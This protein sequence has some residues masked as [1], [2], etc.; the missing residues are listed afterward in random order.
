MVA[1]DEPKFIS[2]PLRF[3]PPPLPPE[4]LLPEVSSFLRFLSPSVQVLQKADYWRGM[5]AVY[6]GLASKDGFP[7]ADFADVTNIHLAEALDG[8]DQE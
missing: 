7:L 1:G 5:A 4:I 3:L 8:L 6:H 2:H